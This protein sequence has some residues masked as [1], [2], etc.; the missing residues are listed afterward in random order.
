[1]AESYSLALAL[2][3]AH[4]AGVPHSATPLRSRLAIS[5]PDSED[6]RT[7][8]SEDPAEKGATVGRRLEEET[9]VSNSTLQGP[10]RVQFSHRSARLR[11]VAKSKTEIVY[12]T[13]S[14][15]SATLSS[16][17]VPERHV[18]HPENPRLKLRDGNAFQS[19][20]ELNAARDFTRERMERH[21]KTQ[22][23]KDPTAFISVQTSLDSALAL[24]VQKYT[25]SKKC[26]RLLFVAKMDVSGLVPA[27][28]KAPMKTIKQWYNALDELMPVKYSDETRNVTIPI[29]VMD[30][31]PYDGEPH[32]RPDTTI[33]EIYANEGVVWL[34]LSE[35]T[36]SD[37][38]VKA[39]DT[40]A[41]EW[42]A[43]GRIPAECVTKVLRFDGQTLHPKKGANPVRSLGSVEKF[44]WNFDEC[45]W[46]HQPDLSDTR[47]YFLQDAGEKRK[48][49]IEVS[50]KR[51][52][53]RHERLST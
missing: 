43:V 31:E 42:L 28:L 51:A 33:E 46:L 9:L 25:A 3:R 30:E 17:V 26:P 18:R 8:E 13:H 15:L 52:R 7:P 24:A 27:I 16:F 29:W 49:Q 6:P 34:C 22:M 2:G 14:E 38:E 44:Y 50:E 32:T 36:Q 20:Q 53:A 45:M 48:R 4:P 1:M 10:L 19:V 5:S 40:H 12:R 39:A 23:V 11:A 37:L 35:L 47:P 41:K 21:L